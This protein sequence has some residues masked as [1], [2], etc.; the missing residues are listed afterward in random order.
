M[1]HLDMALCWFLLVV[2]GSSSADDEFYTSIG[3]MTELLYTEQDLVASL[4]DY[5]R[6]EENKLERI[7]R[8]AQ[9]LADLSAF[10]LEDPEGF[11]GHPVNA[12]KLLNRI[13]RKWSELESLVLTDVSH[14]FVSDVAV[15]R[16]RFPDEGDRTGVAEALLRLQDT[17][18]LDTDSLA[19]GEL[20][21]TSR[22]RGGL[23]ADDCYD[24]GTVAYKANDFYH[25]ELWMSQALRQLERGETP[26]TVDAV[27]LLDYRGYSLYK[28]G[29]LERAKESAE[30]LLE[31]DPV[32]ERANANLKYFKYQ[33]AKEKTGEE[34][35]ETLTR[36]RASYGGAY[37]RLCRGDSV[38]LTP[39]RRSR[40]FC[41]YHDNRGHPNL[42]I[43]P[44]KEEDVW[45]RP[46]IVRYHD[47]ASDDD[48]EII[49]ELAKP[50]LA[51]SKVSDGRTNE[52]LAVP[53]RI[54]QNAWL[55]DKQHAGV[56]RAVRRMGDITGL[57][58][59]T[60]EELQ[61][62]NYGVGGQYEPHFDFQGD[63]VPEPY[64]HLGTGNRIATW[65]LYISDVPAGGATVFPEVGAVV[66][67]I[68]GS[69]VFWYNL[70][71]NGKGDYQTRHA[72]CPVLVG[73]K[74][75]SNKWL[76]ERGQ[77][78]RRRCGLRSSD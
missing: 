39:R 29:D 26:A 24:L 54:S 58:T 38:E 21:G 11:L 50:K 43:G 37:E 22:L 13:D 5:I 35:P 62:V 16:R 65:L 28:Q 74:W 46:R 1:V 18:E 71:L 69:A 63:E 56:D 4:E 15:G 73:S 67:P 68:K 60:A 70:R 33:L 8:W 23:T 41:R 72:A 32:N 76:H 40:L 2:I 53:S 31:I 30:R 20:P 45:D 12:F 19:K 10:A 59:S 64:A 7:K 55:A 25:T 44:A 17:Y 51:R 77:E 42:R 9:K 34:T 57:D 27:T 78:F 6:A 36:G 48:M 47:V 3:H 66:W 52:G 75:V 61:V 49:K 14:G